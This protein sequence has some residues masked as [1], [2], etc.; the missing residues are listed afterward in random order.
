VTRMAE[1]AP[2]AARLPRT[3]MA[4]VAALV[5]AVLALPLTLGCAVASAGPA[6]ADHHLASIE[7]TSLDPA[8]GTPRARLRAAGVLH[9]IG[10]L[11]LSEVEVRLRISRTRLNSRG[12]LTAVAAGRTSS[13]DGDIVARQR[14]RGRLA[15]GQLASFD[16]AVDLKD[17]DTL[18][19]FGV[20]VLN[21][22]VVA[23][24]RE[25]LARAA[26]V[27]T[28]LPWVPA[29]GDFKPAGFAWLWPLVA[30]PVRLANGRYVDD[31][32]AGEMA[33]EGRLGR[34]T[35]AG[36]RLGQQMPLTWVVDPA[37]L[38]TAADMSDGYRVRAGDT[39]QPDVDGSGAGTA[40]QWLDQVRAASRLGD[41]ATL[42]YADPDV[43]ALRR[44]GLTSDVLAARGLGDAMAAELL[45][46]DVVAD[47]AWP[48]DGYA[49]RATLRTLRSV[50]MQ[51]VVLNAGAIPTELT[52]P[53]TPTGRVDIGT[54]DGRLTGLLYDP[55]LTATLGAGADQQPLLAAQRFVAE[56][57]MI[58]AELPG[59][60]P[61]RTI[62][63]APPRQ[64]APPPELLDRI[65]SA[66]LQAPWLSPVSIADLRASK[67]PEIDREPL[68]YPRS[69]RRRELPGAYLD[70]VRD[71]H[72][73]I[74]TF[75]AVLTEPEAIVPRLDAAVF[76]L[77]SIWW[78]N[79]D[80]RLGRLTGTR[81]YV[82]EL[83]DRVQVLP[84][85]YTFGSKSG[86]IPLTVSNNLTQA[87]S[88]RIGLTPSPPRLDVGTVGQVRIPAESKV[89]VEVPA[90]A[91]ANGP[92]VIRT[93]L[94]TPAG[95]QYGQAVQL[96]I[97]VT[98]Y[99]TVALAITGVAAAVLFAAAGYRLFRR[100]G[101][102]RRTAGPP[103]DGTP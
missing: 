21:V 79:H 29:R 6:A 33:A 73:T 77:E 2:G 4:V 83:R 80:D 24:S 71:L 36:S 25:G 44:Q 54:R 94:L 8:I 84:G 12:E 17:V 23:R 78:R 74:A 57:A 92:V 82:L 55:V 45:G 102:A 96:R 93:A 52:L 61:E 76:R 68:T 38:E 20:H 15:S 16:V 64:W 32:L 65:V 67:P 22:E 86:T 19:E 42:P 66:S 48:A 95:D 70:A 10:D 30:P 27:R 7:L 98:Q 3:T 41:V 40:Q 89:Q 46:R 1:P 34:I 69:I 81:G 101:A 62:L 5:A 88:V 26:I 59:I 11:T 85:S 13:R 103:A 47:L 56:T 99:G 18:Q 53:F 75:S 28:F 51:A 91:I 87:V 31:G 49:D 90:T 35:A 39:S 63:I 60:G 100:A 43:V 72:S 37:L 9:V 50:G 58:T 97:Q 14:L